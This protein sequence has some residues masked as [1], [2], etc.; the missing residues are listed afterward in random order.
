M[1]KSTFLIV[2]QF[3]IIVWFAQVII[4]LENVH[5][6]MMV[7]PCDSKPVISP[8]FQKCFREY[9]TGVRQTRTSGIW[10]LLYALGIM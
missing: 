9:E 3:V 8:E 7:N 5:Y 2:V 1:K 4:R 6:G 10:H